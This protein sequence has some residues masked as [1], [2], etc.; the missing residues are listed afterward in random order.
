MGKIFPKNMAILM[1]PINDPLI[2]PYPCIHAHDITDF[3]LNLYTVPVI[4]II[5]IISKNID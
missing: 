4:T 5:N 2:I 3:N 1:A